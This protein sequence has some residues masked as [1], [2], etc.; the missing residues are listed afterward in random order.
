M[1][2][3]DGAVTRYLI[4]GGG[5]MLARDLREALT[6][7]SVTSLG[8]QDL[9][10]TDAA[11]VAAAI[12]GHDVVINTAA[13]TRV[14]DAETHEHDALAVNATGAGTLAAA[15]RHSGARLVQL[16]TD[17]V[18]DGR[19]TSP[20]PENHPIAPLGAY[21]RTKAEGERLTLAEHPDGTLVVRTAWLYGAGGPNFPRTMLTLSDSRDTVSVVADQVGQ[22]T[23]TADLAQTIVDLLDADAAPG[24][25]HASNSGQAS[26][27][28]FARAVFREAGLDEN[29]VIPVSSDEFP[30]AAPRPAYSVLGDGA[31]RATGLPALR[32]WDEALSAAWLAGAL[33]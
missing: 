5:G 24:I 7:R 15:A 19:G 4:T 30:R 12:D 6:G 2:T 18:F 3:A 8:R 14:D 31:L 20:Y 22:P 21:G 33:R 23:W 28:D 27:F 26:W 16:S 17:Y 13:Y 1:A 9:D 11:A 25:Y 10:V 29:R 32:P